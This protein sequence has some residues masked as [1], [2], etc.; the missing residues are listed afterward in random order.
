MIL[1]VSAFCGVEY[2][3]DRRGNVRIKR[4]RRSTLTDSDG[5]LK[6]DIYSPHLCSGLRTD[7]E[8]N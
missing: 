6:V 1:G 7:K 3:L 5:S 4:M 2:Q 8:R